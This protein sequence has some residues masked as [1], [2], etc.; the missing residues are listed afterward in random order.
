MLVQPL[1]SADVV[2]QIGG[3]PFGAPE[4]PY[5]HDSSNRQRFKGKLKMSD[6]MTR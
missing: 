1:D 5:R 4:N 6:L 2:K 3:P